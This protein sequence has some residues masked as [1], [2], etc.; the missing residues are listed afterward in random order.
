MAGRCLDSQE[1]F[2]VVSGTSEQGQPSP[3]FLCLMYSGHVLQWLSIPVCMD[4]DGLCHGVGT[5]AELPHAP[6]A[7]GA[8]TKYSPGLVGIVLEQPVQGMLGELRA[9]KL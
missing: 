5:P 1:Q 8:A 6:A 4:K 3:T 2:A 7:A 9:A